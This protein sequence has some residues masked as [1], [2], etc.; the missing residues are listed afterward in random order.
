MNVHTNSLQPKLNPECVFEDKSS[1][2]KG[3]DSNL[4]Y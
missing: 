1:D 2:L 4:N 3:K